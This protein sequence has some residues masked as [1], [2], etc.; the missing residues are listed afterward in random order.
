MNRQILEACI[1]CFIA[2]VTTFFIA[3]LMIRI[4]GAKLNLRRLK[5]IHSCQDGGVQSLAF[6]LTVPLFLMSV[7]FI[8]QVS[9]L[10]IGTMVV[11]YSAYAAARAATVWI[12]AET[13]ELP[14][15]EL[16][17][18]IAEGEPAVVTPN[19]FDQRPL[20]YQKIYAAA[21]MAVAPISPSRATGQVMLAQA[22]PIAQSME[23]A[24]GALDPTAVNNS[25]MPGRIRNKLAYA[26]NNTAVRI[27]F[28]DKH[29]QRGPTYNPR[30]LVVEDDGTTYREWNRHEIGWDDPV[31]VTVSH[32]FAMI[33]GPGR[34]LAKYLVRADGQPD[35]VSDRID[36][37]GS[38]YTTTIWASATMTND[39]FKSVVPYVQ[40]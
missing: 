1:P 31:T 25:R 35:T 26:F 30:R 29:T 20:K 17:F 10:M 33:P 27:E 4:S 3:W 34:F 11:N 13:D 16:W 40:Q 9:Q 28:E 39:G 22:E 15:N 18:D 12:A 2:L 7:M 21:A 23:R 37:N 6:V 19:D 32:D 8:V 24:Y 36:R 38:L 5:T 14:Q